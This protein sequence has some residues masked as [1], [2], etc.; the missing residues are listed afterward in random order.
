MILRGIF[1]PYFNNIELLNNNSH[2]LSSPGEFLSLSFDQTVPYYF[3][4]H[5]ADRNAIY[6]LH[7]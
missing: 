3:Q 5:L 4:R 1:F 6:I 2:G 7:R